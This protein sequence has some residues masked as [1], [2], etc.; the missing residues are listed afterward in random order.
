MKVKNNALATDEDSHRESDG[1]YLEE[2]HLLLQGELGERSREKHPGLRDSW[3][4][5]A[6]G[7]IPAQPTRHDEPIPHRGEYYY[8]LK[9][10]SACYV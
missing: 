2:K 4:P 3:P 1:N 10:K 9:H 8:I 7:V 6:G 5:Q